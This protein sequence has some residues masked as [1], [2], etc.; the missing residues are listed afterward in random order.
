MSF[1]IAVQRSVRV[2]YD[3]RHVDFAGVQAML[4]QAGALPEGLWRRL[5]T[6]VGQS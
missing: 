3:V 5:R 1:Q 6:S 4:N 2:R